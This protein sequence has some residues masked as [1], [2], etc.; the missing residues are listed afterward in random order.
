MQ[1]QLPPPI[2]KEINAGSSP[3][4]KYNPIPAPKHTGT[5]PN[6]LSRWANSASEILARTCSSPRSFVSPTRAG[7]LPEIWLAKG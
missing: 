3:R 2:A 6:K 7:T 1:G 4:V 5:Q